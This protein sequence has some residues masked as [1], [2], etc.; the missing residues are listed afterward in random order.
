[1][2]MPTD[3]PKSLTIRTYQVGFG[4]CFLL[5]FEYPA[6]KKHV[7]IDFGS[8]GLPKDAPDNLMQ[9]VAK[10]IKADCE[11][12][13]HVVV[14]TH[15]HKDH[16]SG[17]ATK[18]DKTGTGDII[19]ALKPDLVVQPWTEEPGLQPDATAPAEGNGQK[20][21]QR[22][23]AAS[24]AQMQNYFEVAL[25]NL[26]GLR[27]MIDSVQ[28]AELDFLGDDNISNRS[29]IENLM[30]M[31]KDGKSSYV[32]FGKSSRLEEVL[33]GV[34]V[35]V[36]GPP[37][38]E[39]SQA[40]RSEKSKDPDEFWQ[41]TRLDTPAFAAPPRKCLFENAEV[42]DNPIYARWFREQAAQVHA[43]SLLSLVRILDDAMNNTSVILLF[44]VGGKLLLFPGDAQIE[45]WSYALKHEDIQERL[46]AV[47]VY[48]VGHH[49]SLN[50]TPKA[51]LWS[52]FQ[53]KNEKEGENRLCTLLSTMEG[54]HGSVKSHTEVP[55]EALLNELKTESNLTAT[56]T[57]KAGELSRKV[58][59]RFE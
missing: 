2:V 17:F 43:E 57:Y 7:L 20:N 55:R 27:D 18:A 4:D 8:T 41:L 48:K 37:T 15:R 29:A 45:N 13:L 58:V 9:Q 35:T 3:T 24:L 47:S 33:P 23:Y 30:A 36:L 28:L 16:I 53:F 26:D 40:I 22:L 12:K 49:G 11:N 1:M 52:F 56:N 38:L 50:A 44:D 54:K 19:A 39:Q 42:E 46:K 31:G 14:A 32:H 25:Q 34:K 51:S 6:E 59:I 21:P 5:S 10:Q